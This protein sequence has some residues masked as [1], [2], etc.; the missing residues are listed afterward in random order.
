LKKQ[1]HSTSN[2]QYG[3]GSVSANDANYRELELNRIKPFGYERRASF[4]TMPEV[5]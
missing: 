3:E 1:K 4:Q 5:F 2:N